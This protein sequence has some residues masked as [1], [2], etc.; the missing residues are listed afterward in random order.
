MNHRRQYYLKYVDRR[1]RLRKLIYFL[2]FAILLSIVIYDS[3]QHNLPFHYILYMMLGIAMS[4][5]L[6][7]TQKAERRY[8]DNKLTVK[9]NISS[10]LII[11]MVIVLRRF[12]FPKVLSQFNVI[13]ISDAVLLIVM[14]WFLGRIQILSK[15]I[16]NEVF[17]DYIKKNT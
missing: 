17:V 14:G 2:I 10:I 11:I 6:A 15:Q 5:L 9:Y 8:S 4:E 13:Y 1:V 16:E 3:H 7:R 12:V